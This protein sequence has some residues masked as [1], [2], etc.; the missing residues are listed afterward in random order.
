MIRIIYSFQLFLLL[1]ITTW[2]LAAA[3]I[4]NAATWPNQD[5]WPRTDFSQST[6]S[7]KEFKSGGPPKDGIPAIDNPVF[8]PVGEA[9]YDPREPVIALDINGDVRAYPLS[10]L[11]WH[12]IVN[13]TVGGTPV[14][15]T[16][17]PLC[18]ASVVFDRRI[19]GAETTFGVSGI[20]RKSDM[21]MYDRA[22]ESW[23]QQFT[24]KAIVGKHA[25]KVLTRLPSRHISFEIFK[26]ANPNGKVLVPN[27]QKQRD[28]GRNPY[29]DYESNGPYFNV[30]A[31]V[32]SGYE[33]M[34]RVIV[35]GETAWRMSS[36]QKRKTWIDGDIRLSWTAGQA[37]ALDAARVKDGR[38]VGNVIVERRNDEGEWALT[39]YDVTYAFVYAS[40]SDKPDWRE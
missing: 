2:T 16:F 27:D 1:S 30:F 6:I 19:S 40:F 18:N 20:L 37:S 31:K 8:V 13:D 10:I 4:A 35:S 39:P 25:G 26:R 12:E 38:D 7:A 24:G 36:L 17:C 29:I 5:Q 23:W 32:P 9:K 28:Y 21:V 15:V 14:A 33:K 22:T 11:M 3:P 34:E